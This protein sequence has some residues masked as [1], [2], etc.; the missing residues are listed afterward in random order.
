RQQRL[1]FTHQR[2]YPG[3]VNIPRHWVRSNPQGTQIAFL[4]RDDNGV[5][6]LWL[7]SPAG[8]E[9]HQLTHN[10][11]D[12]QSAFN[13]HPSGKGLGFVL[14]GRIAMCDAQTGA[15]TFLTADHAN[16]PSADAVIFSPDGQFITWMEDVAGF[17][18]LWITETAR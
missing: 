13:W 11:S 7:I 12:I 15:V 10:A 6:Q 1:T 14:E 3:L 18:Q 8:G 4:M 9:P 17:R 2:A 5:V 16:T